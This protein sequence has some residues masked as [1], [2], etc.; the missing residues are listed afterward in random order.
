MKIHVTKQAGDSLTDLIQRIEAALRQQFRKA[1]KDEPLYWYPKEVFDDAV[2]VCA[3]EDGKLYRIPYTLEGES[4]DV[5]FGQPVQVEEEYVEVSP[6]EGEEASIVAM[7]AQSLDKEGWAWRIQVCAFGLSSTRDLWTREFFE[8]GLPRLNLKAVQCY[9]DHPTETEMRE[10]PERSVRKLVGW[11]DNF[12]IT[13]QGVDADFHI[14]RSAQWLRDDI[15][16]AYQK[17]NKE[18]YGFSVFFLTRQSVVTWTDGGQATKHE[19]LVKP[20]SIDVVTKA[21]AGGMI[22]YALASSRARHNEGVR[23]IM[24]KTMLALLFKADRSR[25]QLV[26]QSLVTAGAEGVTIET[27]EDQ[28][29]EQAAGNNELFDT[30]SL[31]LQSVATPAQADADMVK[32]P[33]CGKD[34]KADATTCPECKKA[35][36]TA[37]ADRST[38]PAEIGFSQLPREL[39]DGLI[40]QA[41]RE[42]Q[43]PEAAQERIR[44]HLGD[45]A[46]LGDVSSLVELTRGTLA[47][48]A[49][50]GNVHNPRVEVGAAEY[51]KYAIGLAKAFDMTRD[52]F[53][54]TESNGERVVRQSGSKAFEPDQGM[55]NTVPKIRSLKEFYIEQTG[56]REVTGR[57]ARTARLTRQAQTPWYSSDF[58]FLL[59]D[60]MHKRMLASYREVDYGWQRVATVKDL[61][62]FR[63]QH[64][65]NWGYLA[66]LPSVTETGDYVTATRPTDT[67]ETYTPGSKGVLVEL[68]RKDILN[69]DIG[70]FARV[71]GM[72]G[73]A[74]HRTLAKFVWLTNLFN[75]P[76]MSDSLT[77]YHASHFNILTDL[78]TVPGLT[79]AL[80]LLMNQTEPS[81]GEKLDISLKGITLVIPPTEYFNANALT[82]FNNEAGG[83]TDSVAR[84]VRRLEITP[85]SLPILTDANDWAI[86]ANKADV[87]IVEIGFINGNVEPEFFSLQGELHEKA[88][89]SDIITRHKVRHEYGGAPVD[90]RGTVKSTPLG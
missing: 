77:L 24:K 55:W 54:G 35:M 22:K 18:L 85:V 27:T 28:L 89:N 67:E 26:R 87:E 3:D 69:D 14:K 13:A 79:A 23:P 52:Q 6:G 62:D 7:I 68:T 74:A 73:R 29:A 47:L 56:D 30:V 19:K 41:L 10:L 32:C 36:A 51:D 9:A 11:L 39:R 15:L 1:D 53:I 90:Y 21:A 59:E 43:L 84:E 66:D 37:Q 50:S 88:F 31:V 42:S 33:H 78:L 8:D 57:P 83:N 4:Q 80:T 45:T 46:T 48:V 76:T 44:T 2:I 40:A 38:Q 70:A 75:N 71:V 82:D 64:V 25:F 58:T 12:Q 49:Q 65:I 17:G 20:I 86:F 5:K 60:V 34:A 63:T 61:K 16:D 72:Q 81:S